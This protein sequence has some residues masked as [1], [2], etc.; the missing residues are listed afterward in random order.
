MLEA[1]WFDEVEGL[2]GR[3]PP[4]LKPLQALGYRHLIN[5]LIGRWSWEEALT[6][7]TRDTRRYAKRQL[8]WFSSDPEV[9]WFYPGQVEEMAAV[10]AGFFG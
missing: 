1:G 5:Y 7:L 8:T 4:T 10:L 6:W 2:L 3:Y 9:R